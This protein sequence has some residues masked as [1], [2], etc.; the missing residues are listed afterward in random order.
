MDFA[1]K[2][3]DLRIARDITQQEL[4]KRLDMSQGN[5]ANYESGR[6]LP[7]L[8]AL[9]K[10]AHFF[11]VPSAYLM[12][13]NDDAYSSDAVQEDVEA[14]HQNPKLRLLFDKSKLLSDKDLDA[15]LSVINAIA[16]ERV[17]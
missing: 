5:I 8:G 11:N 7:S 17:E 15:V 12:R 10:I 16:R 6:N 4:A 9:H 13:T 1:T 14:L 2:L 3:R